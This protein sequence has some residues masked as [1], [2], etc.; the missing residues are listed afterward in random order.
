VIDLTQLRTRFRAKYGNEPR[1]FRAPGRVNIIG[2]HTDYNVG[3]VLPCAI[4][5][6]AYVAGCLRPDRVIRV[7]SLNFENEVEFDLD[8][9]SEPSAKDWTRLVC[10]VAIILERSGFR[11]RGADL[12]IESD[13]PIGVGL[14]S[15]AALEIS[16]AFALASLSGHVID[17]MRL[18]KVGQAAENDFAGVRCGIMDQFTSV[19]GQKGNALFL[20]CRSLEWSGIPVS[21]VRFVICNTKTNHDLVDG[22]YNKRRAECEAAAAFLEKDS[23]REAS[24]DELDR[25]VEM[26][27][28]LKKRA[29]HVITENARVLE[30]VAALRSNDLEAVGQRINESHASL[31][32]DFEVSCEELDLMVNL[33]RQ[34]LGVLGA[35]MMGGG[36]GGCTINLVRQGEH[37]DFAY[38]IAGR[39]ERETG[40]VPESYECEI[41]CG[42]GELSDRYGYSI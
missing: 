24:L 31:R 35:R 19:F 18:A 36:F 39:Y 37:K 25:A 12:L 9:D 11:L 4:D 21:T 17:G 33:A 7:A 1:I 26:P 27:E 40:I 38:K 14:S 10:G 23:L 28:T 5:L 42:V 8:G 16:V 6:G 41:A 29:R 32:D 13:V 22:E 15:S 3:F 2:E 20:D 34:D 30:A